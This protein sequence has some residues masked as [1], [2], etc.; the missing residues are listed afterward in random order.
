MNFEAS[1]F[2]K[3]ERVELGQAAG[4]LGLADAGGADHQDVLGN[5]VVGDVGRKLL[6]AEAVAQGDAYRFFGV[7]LPDDVL[8]QFLD[9]FLGGQ[10][11]ALMDD[12]VAHFQS[13][14]MVKFLLV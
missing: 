11:V 6:A 3:G 1:T 4:D 14:S 5:D 2:R 8:V 12:G 10:F 13:S 7:F 9:D